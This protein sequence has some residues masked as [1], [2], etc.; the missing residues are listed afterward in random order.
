MM[1]WKIRPCAPTTLRWIVI[2][3]WLD[4]AWTKYRREK[5]EKFNGICI[6]NIL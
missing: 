2:S 5:E 4:H 3:D 6:G 1:I